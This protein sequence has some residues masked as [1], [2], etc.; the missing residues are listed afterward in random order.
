MV[1]RWI[2]NFNDA[3]EYVEGTWMA[4]SEDRGGPG[5]VYIVGP[6]P[7]VRLNVEAEGMVL[8]QRIALAF[9]IAEML[10]RATHNT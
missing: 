2:P 7:R 9:Q 6:D 1:D 8:V 3:R 5:N 10:N 4:A